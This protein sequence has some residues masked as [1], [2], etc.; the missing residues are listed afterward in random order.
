MER[1]GL[2]VTSSPSLADSSESSEPPAPRWRLQATLSSL[3]Y[4]TSPHAYSW[5]TGT[6]FLEQHQP[7]FPLYSLSLH[8]ETNSPMAGK[9]P[10]LK[11]IK[12]QFPKASW[13][14]HY[15]RSWGEFKGPCQKEKDAERRGAEEKTKKAEGPHYCRGN[16][17]GRR[18]SCCGTGSDHYSIHQKVLMRTPFEGETPD[19]PQG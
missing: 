19:A 12:T 5:S 3:L 1:L 2:A 8:E 10:L 16:P 4:H 13:N 14:E 9:N 7:H 11:E 17:K 18:S 6:F 15:K